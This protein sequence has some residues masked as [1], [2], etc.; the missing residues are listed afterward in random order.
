MCLLLLSKAAYLEHSNQDSFHNEAQS[1]QKSVPSPG[2]SEGFL[3]K[4]W[5][6]RDVRESVEVRGNL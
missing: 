6:W 2:N 4:L 5:G 1:P 3:C